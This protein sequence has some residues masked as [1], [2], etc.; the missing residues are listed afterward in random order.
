MCGA[1]NANVQPRH[2]GRTVL[3]SSNLSPSSSGSNKSQKSNSSCRE[4]TLRVQDDDKILMDDQDKV[5]M[6]DD[7]ATWH[8]WVALVL[9]LPV[10]RRN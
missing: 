8:G 7:Y 2:T 4:K 3:G 5:T 6:S 9:C 1:D 10:T